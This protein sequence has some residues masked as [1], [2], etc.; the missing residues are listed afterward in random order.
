MDLSEYQESIKN[1][2]KYPPEL[3]AFTTIY[4]I[5]SNTGIL[6][7]KIQEIL[8]RNDPTILPEEKMKLAITLGDILQWL[9]FTASSI[10]YDLSQI[11]ALNLRKNEM[12][13]EKEIKNN[14]KQF[15]KQ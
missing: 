13:K 7:E 4:G 12:I 9:S 5:I 14:Q 10:D 3:G 11:A 6:S 8:N 15:T 1:Y 2:A